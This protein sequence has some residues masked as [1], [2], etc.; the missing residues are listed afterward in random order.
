MIYF[1]HEIVRRPKLSW[2][3]SIREKL[4]GTR[5]STLAWM[6]AAGTVPGPSSFG[7]AFQKYIKAELEIALRHRGGRP[8]FF[9]LI[10]WSAEWFA[11]RA[12]SGWQARPRNGRAKLDGCD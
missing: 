4:C 9:A 5:D 7:L 12:P 2:T 11:H 1:R 8:S 6:I 10:L 3:I